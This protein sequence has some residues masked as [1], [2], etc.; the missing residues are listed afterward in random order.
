MNKRKYWSKLE[1]RRQRPC[2]TCH[3]FIVKSH[4]SSSHL[5]QIIKASVMNEPLERS[6]S[7][8]GSGRREGERKGGVFK[9]QD[10]YL[11]FFWCGAE[12]AAEQQRRVFFFFLCV[13]FLLC[14]FCRH[15]VGRDHAVTDYDYLKFYSSLSRNLI[16]FFSFKVLTNKKQE[17]KKNTTW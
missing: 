15:A 11:I 17:E 10:K 13:F 12:E 2:C 5:Q 14:G 8:G 1:S 3:A 16:F 7:V 9:E 6:L 4:P